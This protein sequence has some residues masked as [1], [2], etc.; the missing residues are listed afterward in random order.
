MQ[1]VHK[2]KLKQID[3]VVET[4]RKEQYDRIKYGSNANWIFE[5]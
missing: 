3:L 4:K 5:R 2:M 1:Y